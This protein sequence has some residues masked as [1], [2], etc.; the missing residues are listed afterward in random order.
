MQSGE[1]KIYEIEV[2]KRDDL[3]FISQTPALYDLIFFFFL[4]KDD[5]KF[6]V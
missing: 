6:I 5:S 2:G 3:V 1:T 4:L